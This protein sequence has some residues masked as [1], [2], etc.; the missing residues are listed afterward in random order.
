MGPPQTLGQTPCVSTELDTALMGLPAGPE[1]PLAW[2]WG[3]IRKESRELWGPVCRLKRGE[4]AGPQCSGGLCVD[5]RGKGTRLRRTRVS[6]REVCL[7]TSRTL[8]FVMV[9][10]PGE[11]RLV[12]RAK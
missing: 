12:L 3:H 2:D 8:Y 11:G 5:C 9:T 10:P 7:S 4:L 1:G 6:P